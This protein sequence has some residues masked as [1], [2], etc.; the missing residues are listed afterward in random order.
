MNIH[1]P[2]NITESDAASY[3]TLFA[4]QLQKAV[5][6]IAKTVYSASSSKTE[7][8][9]NLEADVETINKLV[10]CFYQNTTCA[11]FKSILSEPQWIKY[12]KLLESVMPFYQLSFYTSV[13]ENAM[14]GKFISLELLKFFSRNRDLENLNATECQK[15]SESIQKFESQSPKTI[16]N[17]KFVNNSTCVAS[18]VYLVSSV[19]PVFDKFY[20][21][22]ILSNTDKYSSWTESSWNGVPIQIR[23]FMFPDRS[24]EILTLSMGIVTIVLA[25]VLTFFT[26]KYS[27]KILGTAAANSDQTG[28]IFT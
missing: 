4:K 13:N 8:S 25:F 24:M 27:N 21:D 23:L 9:V 2:A 7:A 17:L 6:S 11:F 5:S 28:Q 20:S 1:F 14:S 15:N 26:N 3:T 16:R 22:G 18:S 12:V 10:Y 19:S